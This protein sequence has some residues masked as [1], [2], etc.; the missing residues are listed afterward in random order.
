MPSSAYASRLRLRSGGSKSCLSEAEGRFF[1]SISGDIKSCLSEAEDSFCE[2]DN[3]V[4]KIILT[5]SNILC[6]LNIFF[7]SFFYSLQHY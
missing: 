7:H 2:A 5:L 3:C 6:R 4:N 1:N